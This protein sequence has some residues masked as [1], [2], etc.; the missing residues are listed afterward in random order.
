MHD[1]E[2]RVE[3]HTSD[4]QWV[5][6]KDGQ[7]NINIYKDRLCSNASNTGTDLA[8]ACSGDGP[9]SVL[10]R[11]NIKDKEVNRAKHLKTIKTA[12]GIDFETEVDWVPFAAAAVTKGYTDR[13][14][15]IM[16]DWYLGGL[17]GS[18]TEF[19]KHAIQKEAFIESFGE[20][21][22]IS[23]VL[24]DP[25]P[26]DRQ[27]EYVWTSNN[28]GVLTINTT[29][30]RFCSNTSNT[31]SDLS[32]ACSGDGPMTV[33]TRKNIS[34]QDKKRAAHLK[35]IMT[36]SGIQFEVE[37]D[38]VVAAETA[39]TKGYTDRVGEIIY[40]WYLGGLAG[41]VTS[42]C[43]DAIQ[44]ES[45]VE[46]FGER[47][48]I[49]F[50]IDATPVEGHEKDYQ[51][52]AN[53]GGVL[54]I[55][56]PTERMCSN[57]SNTGSDL[58]KSC[59]GDGPLTVLTRKNI[60]DKEVSMIKHLKTIEKDSGIKF[61]VEVDW[62]SVV[63]AFNAK[64][65][66]DRA[67]EIVYDWY[68][69]GLAGSITSYCKDA[70]QKESLVES[71]A[72]RHTISFHIHDPAP[73][74]HATDYVWVTNESGVLTINISKDRACSNTSNTGSDLAKACSG[75]GPL[76]VT[77]RKNI[78]DKETERKKHLTRIQKATGI[79]FEVEVDWVEF[80]AAAAAKGNTDRVGEIVYGWY[81]DGLAGN[82]EKLCKD[83]MAK[84]AV[85][86][87]CGKKTIQFRLVPQEELGTNYQTVT[88]SDDG[89]MII[90]TSKDRI[91]S[92]TSNTGSDI[93][94]RL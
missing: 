16:Y 60:K 32:K 5:T 93:E 76:T 4:Y 91:C 71:F 28:S 8:K 90:S 94:S 12:V 78:K 45:F 83:E 34:D 9:L 54:E 27:S 17:A 69:A 84:E 23:F 57:C 3:G 39:K 88:F 10:T 48:Q 36:A 81:L 14:G 41:S 19:A 67:G 87:V 56:I 53:N 79:E 35:T 15:E 92:N 38:W 62:V 13:V 46:S 68:L 58:A 51:F 6:N 33:A 49:V 1:G 44:K 42:Y 80:A 11:K 2:E 25:A 30:S 18:I 21:K 37:V 82:L 7:L 61:E 26:E 22:T 89:A 66:S 72:E 40:D 74:G 50:V 75:D 47:K 20:R 63:P 64:G 86:E 65:Y 31:G 73:E 24:H 29:V 85:G 52:T 59:S 77:T 70:I 55:H 43:K